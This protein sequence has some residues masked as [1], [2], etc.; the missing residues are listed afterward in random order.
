MIIELNV[1][2]ETPRSVEIFL[3][4]RRGNLLNKHQNRSKV[5]Q[6]VKVITKYTNWPNE[7][8]SVD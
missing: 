7:H 8:L 5:R 3:S 1:F 2:E 4:G 6:K